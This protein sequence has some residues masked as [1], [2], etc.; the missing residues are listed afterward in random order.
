MLAKEK[1]MPLSYHFLECDTMKSAEDLIMKTAL[2]LIA[3]GSRQKVANADLVELAKEI[4]KAEGYEI[5]EPAFLELAKPTINDGAEQCV[6]K[7][8]NRVIMVPC[9]LFAGVHASNDLR[10]WQARLAKKHRS[11]EWLLAEPIG[12]HP[13]LRT[14]LI[15]R[16][17]EAEGGAK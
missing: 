6:S 3:H 2:L 17:Q 7:G 14:I 1:P 10:A 12:R 11:V 4:Q 9:F 8:A 13:M 15:T 16:A 5:V